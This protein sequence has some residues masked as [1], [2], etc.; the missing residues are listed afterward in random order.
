MSEQQN[1]MAELSK[2]Y[3]AAF[4]EM[5]H[6]VKNSK[7]PQFNSGYADLAGTLNTVRPILAKHGLSV[8]QAPGKVAAVEGVLLASVIT[9]LMHTS[10]QQITVE[11]QMPIAPTFDKRTNTSRVTAQGMGSAV[12]YAR[13]YALAA[14]CGIGQA[15]DDGGAAS[16]VAQI[17]ANA[18]LSDIAA[19]TTASELQFC[20]R[21]VEEL[22]DQRVAD[23]Y[24][25]R[26]K[27][28]KVK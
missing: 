12:S 6:A 28:L 4:A 26:L 10:G 19:A 13:R 17:D 18:L 25:T 3:C 22:G 8:Y 5:T 24:T 23:A 14:V 20:R 15:D 2:A 7:N 11:T 27:A 1:G 9:V 21:S 16:E